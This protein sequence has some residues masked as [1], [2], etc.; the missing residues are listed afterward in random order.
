M[1]SQTNSLTL[2]SFVIGNIKLQI[3][4]LSIN[5]VGNSPSIAGSLLNQGSTTGLYTTIELTKSPLLDAIRQARLNNF[6]NSSSN[7]NASFQQAQAQS[8]SDGQGGFGGGGQGG[9]GGGSQGRS[10]LSGQGGF[11]GGGQGGS[12][13]ATSQQFIGDLTADSPIPFS[14][15]INGL[16]LLQP[17]MYPV[18]FKVTYAD[19]L[20]DSHTVVLT[21]NLFVAKNQPRT[22]TVQ[23]SLLD[24]IFSVVPLPVIIG[25]SIAIAAGIGMIIRRRKSRQKLKMLTGSDTDIVTIMNNSD[26]KQDEPQ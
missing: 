26:K 2:G 20:K 19:D 6:N 4:G 22:T 11:G 16:N 13:G 12:G 10:S 7:G 3:Y 21:E 18:S 9:F 17:G 24:Q 5:Y 15:P 14:I 25:I 8:S 1:G 23:K